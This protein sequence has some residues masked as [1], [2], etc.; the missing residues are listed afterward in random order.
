MAAAALQHDNPK[1]FVS[2]QSIFGDLQ[3]NDR[4]VAAYTQVLRDLHS[5][6]ARTA[7]EHLTLPPK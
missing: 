1:A 3:N 7:L 2:Y 6:G 5:S 4:F